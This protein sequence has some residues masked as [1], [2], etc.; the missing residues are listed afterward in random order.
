MALHRSRSQGRR[1]QT[2]TGSR[3]NRDKLHPQVA[4]W[5]GPFLL[6]GE[7]VPGMEEL[8]GVRS[9]PQRGQRL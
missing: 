6:A 5:R 9:G 7:M 3:A 4:R 1:S 8:A 2:L